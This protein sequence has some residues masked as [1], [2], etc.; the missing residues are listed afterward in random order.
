MTIELVDVLLLLAGMMLGAG[1]VIAVALVVAGEEAEPSLGRPGPR[2]RD[3]A[4]EDIIEPIKP[5]G[6]S[7]R[8]RA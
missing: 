8:H 5:D 1:A 7:R 2:H 4:R 3:T 6:P